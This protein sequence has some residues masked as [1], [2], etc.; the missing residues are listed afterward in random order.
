MDQIVQPT[1]MGAQYLWQAR[2][3]SSP[4]SVRL[5]VGL[6]RGARLRLADEGLATT[7]GPITAEDSTA[8]K[9][10][11][12]VDGDEVLARVEP[13]VT[14]DA[15]DEAVPTFYEIDGDTIIVRFPHR[16]LDL[17][18]PLLIDPQVTETWS[19]GDWNTGDGWGSAQFLQGGLTNFSFARNCCNKTGLQVGAFQFGTYN[20]G[21]VGQWAWTTSPTTYIYRADL[22]G[23]DQMDAGNILFTGIFNTPGARWESLFHDTGNFTGYARTHT[24]NA[25]G[26]AVV[27]GI[28][29]RG[30]YARNA[31]PGLVSMSGVT[32]YLGDRRP[33]TISASEHTYD[34]RWTNQTE[35]QVRLIAADQGLGLKAV[36]VARTDKGDPN[37]GNVLDG[38]WL[39]LV[40][41]S[42]CRGNRRAVCPATFDTATSKDANGNSFPN[43]RLTY[44]L[45]VLPEGINTVRASAHQYEGNQYGTAAFSSTWKVRRDTVQPSVTLDGPAWE[46]ISNGQ[47]FGADDT[48]DL[49]FDASDQHSGVARVELRVDGIT[50]YLDSE[51]CGDACDKEGIWTFDPRQYAV[52]TH[53]AEILV[54]DAANNVAR[55]AFNITTNG[56]SPSTSQRAAIATPRLTTE[57]VLPTTRP[58]LVEDDD[59]EDAALVL[60][61]AW[62]G[63]VETTVFSS[64]DEYSV[65]RCDPQGGF[66]RG[67]VVNLVETPSGP[68]R[69]FTG[70]IRALN[71]GRVI[72]GSWIYPN[73]SDSVWNAGWSTTQ[74][75]LLAATLPPTK[76]LG[77]E[78]SVV[79]RSSRASSDSSSTRC[80]AGDF[81][82][83]NPFRKWP[84]DEMKYEINPANH[85][86]TSEKARKRVTARLID[87][88][89]T[90]TQTLDECGERKTDRFRATVESTTSTASVGNHDDR[91]NVVAF[92]TGKVVDQD[93][94]E[95]EE[96]AEPIACAITIRGQRVTGARPI[97]E[98]DIVFDRRKTW[99]ST[100]TSCS[101]SS[102]YDIWQVS[103]HEFGHALG[104]EHINDGRS[105]MYPRADTCAFSARRKRVLA[106]GD[107]QGVRHIYGR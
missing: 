3:A 22:T 97:E 74:S 95:R 75:R 31:G 47:P 26:N 71:D 107:V 68:L 73:P 52:G 15:D 24:G 103:T 51:E 89:R 98:V 20:N 6:P 104:L 87:G 33:P 29:M 37:T 57:G 59:A 30:T 14:V 19:G 13:P 32:L 79:A 81:R 93:C 80:A 60:T 101:T 83:G 10:V 46:R 58:C 44:K 78:P 12:I 42:L 11:E 1:T 88:G 28:E 62:V 16:S 35:A 49:W 21:A 53:S 65:F 72:Q 106:L 86:G 54:T 55:R 91:K 50:R 36:G 48:D 76:L 90:W 2:S 96:T 23:L 64:N 99:S 4:E 45:D 92:S 38:Y 61:G 82:T 67:Q 40:N 85:P 100:L 84:S 25:E 17:Q 34:G 5:R 41:N 43:G 9:A 63:G 102:G 66:L 69:L 39:S 8:P 18:Y 105:V 56:A 77:K 94:A 70:S 27:F 7:T